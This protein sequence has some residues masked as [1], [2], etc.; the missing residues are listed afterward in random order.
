MV[1][2]LN[3]DMVSNA[4]LAHITGADT[5]NVVASQAVSAT[6]RQR[7]IESTL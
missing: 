5:C 7:L 2:I 6:T 1:S 3:T 4:A